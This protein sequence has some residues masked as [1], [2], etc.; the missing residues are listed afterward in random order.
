MKDS[1][2]LVIGILCAVLCVLAVAYASFTR[3]LD[4]NGVAEIQSKWD[5]RFTSIT[6]STSGSAVDNSSKITDASGLTAT[7][8]FT[9]VAPGD[10]AYCDLTVA[11]NGT[12]PAT[13]KGVSFGALTPQELAASPI[14]VTFTGPSSSLLSA[15]ASHVVRVNAS[16]DSNFKVEELSSAV[17]TKTATI[18]LNYQQDGIVS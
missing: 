9:L 12:L 3:N 16:Y 15:N 4:I 1:K 7:V 17:T 2:N 6:C 11:N 10:F 14:I 5:I 13:Y 8:N 18:T